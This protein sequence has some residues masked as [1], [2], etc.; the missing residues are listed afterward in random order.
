LL[1]AASLMLEHGVDVS[2]C[3]HP[4]AGEYLPKVQAENLHAQRIAAALGPKI[5]ENTLAPPEPTVPPWS[6]KLANQ[7]YQLELEDAQRKADA[8]KHRVKTSE[9]RNEDHGEYG[10]Q[11]QL[12][13]D[14]RVAFGRNGL[15]RLNNRTTEPLGV[16][17]YSQK[18]SVRL[19]D[20]HTKRVDGQI[21][22][23]SLSKPG[24]KPEHGFA[25]DHRLRKIKSR[26]KRRGVP[27][28]L[29]EHLKS[30]TKAREPEHE[31]DS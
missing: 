28:I 23:I 15:P 10:P 18:R 22:V 19:R 12:T 8:S 17:D 29:A 11:S 2:G 7:M 9:Y 1:A 27:F 24:P 4:L 21:A 16:N 26:C 6:Q 30:K 13:R 20:G 3:N 25:L 5:D 14:G 31:H